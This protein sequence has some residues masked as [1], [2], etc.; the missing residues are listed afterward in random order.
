M[1]KNQLFISYI[2]NVAGRFG[3]A[4][5]SIIS[6]LMLV[7][8]LSPED[9][10]LVAIAIM[11]LGLFEVLS[12]MSIERYIVLNQLRA[13]DKINAAWSLD[14]LI[15]IA[16]III[17]FL[18]AGPIA[19]YYQEPKLK[20]AIEVLSVMQVFKVVKNI[21][22]AI[23]KMDMN[24]KLINKILVQAKLAGTITTI[25]LAF[26]LQ[27]YRALIIGTF[28]NIVTET[29]L[30]YVYCRYRPKFSTD[31]E[32][33]MI[34]FSVKLLTRNIFG[35]IRSKLDVALLGAGYGTT[36]TGRYLVAQKFALM[37]QRDLIA[38]ASQPLFSELSR[39][40]N[41]DDLYA[42][43][44]KFLTLLNL[45][46][47]PLIVGINLLSL[48]IETIILGPKWQGSADIVANLAILMLPFSLIPV[49]N[50][51]F[52]HAGKPATSII[53]D[54][55]GIGL[56]LYCFYGLMPADESEFAFYR[57]SVGVIIYGVMIAV[58][59][60]TIGLQI[61]KL[62][63]SLMVPLLAA[64]CMFFTFKLLSSAGV[65][66]L[67]NSIISMLINT[68][69]CGAIYGFSALIFLFLFKHYFSQCAY[70]YQLV[71]KVFLTRIRNRD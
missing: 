64:A 44:Y 41:N 27:D 20:L 6:T 2:W 39:T 36:G 23:E 60:L 3:I 65:L 43:S 9:F 18:L 63:E 26:Y 17:A 57:A 69:I 28:V 13:P 24:F 30:S 45:V 52:D 51:L 53:I 70:A 48:Q 55:L 40:K 62:I 16:V 32:P 33:K 1:A 25:T 4:L 47:L 71:D 21:G 34:N 10:G 19:E 37:A 61:R 66:N 54:V 56:I 11:V 22:L 7:R 67:T 46:I 5:L 42:K 8:L 58:A 31:F 29:I 35:Y 12:E 15:K 49:L 14:V 50:N 59:R 38:P 68:V